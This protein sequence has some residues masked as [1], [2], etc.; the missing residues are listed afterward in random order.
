MPCLIILRE[1]FWLAFFL[2]SFFCPSG[3]PPYSPRRL[4]RT[5]PPFGNSLTA[6]SSAEA[7]SSSPTKATQF[8]TS[9]SVMIGTA[10]I[11]LYTSFAVDRDIL[12]PPT[13]RFRWRALLH[14][15]LRVGRDA[16]F[17]MSCSACCAAMTV[18]VNRSR[19]SCPRCAPAPLP[20]RR[21]PYLSFPMGNIFEDDL[22]V[23]IG[24]DFQRVALPD[25]AGCGGSFRNNDA[26][27]ITDAAYNA[28]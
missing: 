24:E 14:H 9:P 26:S 6:T 7:F 1:R 8:V 18:A 16:L 27:K 5:G 22:A 15:K 28:G 20:V 19:S 17:Q 3:A 11:T 25:A 2:R 4:D 21:R 13:P 23:A 12:C 10:T